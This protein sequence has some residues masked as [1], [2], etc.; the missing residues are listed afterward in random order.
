M[1]THRNLEGLIRVAEFVDLTLPQI[2][3]ELVKIIPRGLGAYLFGYM[4]PK[5]KGSSGANPLCGRS[6]CSG[7]AP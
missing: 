6:R 3:S 5:R 2:K 1:N 4:Y 7:Q